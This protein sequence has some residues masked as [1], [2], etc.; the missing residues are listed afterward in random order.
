VP[1]VE[2]TNLSGR[3]VMVVGANAGL[4]LQAAKH[5][6]SMTPG[7]LILAC[8]NQAKGQAAMAS[9]EQETGFGKSE[10]WSVDL[11]SFSTIVAFAEQFNKDDG[12]LDILVMNAGVFVMK[13]EATADGFELNLGVNHL[14]TS[15]M[16]LLLL[17]SL[18]KTGS[19]ASIASRLVVV[20]SDMHY[21]AAISKKEQ[22]S[23]NILAKLNSKEY[24]TSSVMGQRYPLT[25]LLNVFFIRALNARLSSAPL[26]VNNANPGFCKSDLRHG[27]PFPQSFIAGLVEKA[28]A[29]TAEQGSRQLVYGAIGG[30]E[31]PSEMRGAYVSLG[32][33]QEVS[34]FVL[35]QEGVVVEER[36]WTETVDI[37][38]GFTPKV[39]EIVDR[40]L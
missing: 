23:P 24:C 20:S 21:G 3:T 28:I 18:L 39:R 26:I 30:K 33:I 36:I 38:T 12:R 25:K 19:E 7:R 13:Y 40:H 1:P 5:F 35:S 34:D 11:G 16:S 2:T 6:A 27:M 9:I 37:L 31:D 22:A 15:L 17:P 14:G 32:H 10:L 8:R 29:F 4:G